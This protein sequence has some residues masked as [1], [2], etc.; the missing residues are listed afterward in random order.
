MTEHINSTLFYRY[1]GLCNP[2][3]KFSS[4]ASISAL[5]SK[6]LLFFCSVFML[7][8]LGISCLSLASILSEVLCTDCCKIFYSIGIYFKAGVSDLQNLMPDDLR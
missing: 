7:A 2:V 5:S 4:L 6:C 1:V 3:S 8:Q